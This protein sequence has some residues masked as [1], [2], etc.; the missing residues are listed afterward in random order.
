MK[1][2]KKL[3]AKL[4]LWILVRGIEHQIRACNRK[5]NH[6]TSKRFKLELKLQESV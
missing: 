5:I 3:I 2:L 4:K 6:Y 1:S